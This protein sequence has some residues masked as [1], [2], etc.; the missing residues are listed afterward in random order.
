MAA[1]GPSSGEAS[2]EASESAER[3][4]ERAV[5]YVFLCR[6]WLVLI[7]PRDAAPQDERRPGGT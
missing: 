6:S 3:R 4:D 7:F 5:W 1:D 2:E